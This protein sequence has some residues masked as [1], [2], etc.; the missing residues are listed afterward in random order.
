MSYSYPSSL[1]IVTKSGKIP[2]SLTGKV[3]LYTV[4][5]HKIG[6]VRGVAALLR[7]KGARLHPLIFGGGQENGLRSGT[8]NTF[9]IKQFEYAAQRKFSA[10]EE[11]FTRVSGFNARFR[12]GLDGEIFDI[13]SSP[14]AS[15][16]I[17]SVSAKGLRAE[18]LL[19]LL[20]DA[21]VLVGTGS[22]CSSKNRFSR[23]ILAC[24]IGEKRADGV[25]RI[26][27]SPKN[28]DEEVCRAIRIINENARALA[29]RMR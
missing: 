26:S 10:L 21:G 11:D 20:N 15:P 19:H 2:F 23:V 24:G 3:D 1:F 22:A 7:K 17:L 25:L 9:A 4:S 27:F 6:G 14:D 29:L 28:T 12:D 8:E 18:V 13:L 5:A 16:Y